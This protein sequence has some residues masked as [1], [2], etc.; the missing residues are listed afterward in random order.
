[1]KTPAP[2]GSQTMNKVS[3]RRES[4]GNLDAASNQSLPAKAFHDSSS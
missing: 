3:V 4:T 1:M 2:A